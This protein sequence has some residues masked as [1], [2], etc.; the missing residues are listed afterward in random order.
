MFAKWLGHND[1]KRS[2][3]KWIGNQYDMTQIE[4][5]DTFV[6]FLFRICQPQNILKRRRVTE[7]MLEGRSWM[8][9]NK[10]NVQLIPE[11]RWG[12]ESSQKS[13][14]WNGGWLWRIKFWAE[15]IRNIGYYS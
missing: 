8:T 5:R 15:K 14:E 9:E 4:R 11:W 10:E 2:M 6:Y 12:Q 1:K 7:H 3:T 13:R